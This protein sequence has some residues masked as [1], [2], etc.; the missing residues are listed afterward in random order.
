[1]VEEVICIYGKGDGS[2]FRYWVIVGMVK[3]DILFIGGYGDGARGIGI[4]LPVW[5]GIIEVGED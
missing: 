4:K 3:L 2:F 1:V 5:V